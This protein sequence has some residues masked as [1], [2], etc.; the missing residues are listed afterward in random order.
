[1]TKRD[2]STGSCQQS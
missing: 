1:M 2:S